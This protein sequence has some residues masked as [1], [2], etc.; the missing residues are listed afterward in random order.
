MLDLSHNQLRSIEGKLLLGPSISRSYYKQLSLY[1]KG[2]LLP[3]SH[4]V[5][6]LSFVIPLIGSTYNVLL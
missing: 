1:G 2:H 6:L 4:I 3:P 5:G